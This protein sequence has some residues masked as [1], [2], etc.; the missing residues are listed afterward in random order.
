MTV[1]LF[2]ARR[3]FEAHQVELL[4]AA[5]RVLRSGSWILG[6]EVRAF[7]LEV[8]EYLGVK[9]AVGVASGSD[10]LILALKSLGIGPGDAVVT[11]PFTFF[12]T[13]GAIVNAGAE[14]V[15]ADIDP[16]S[17]DL[18]PTC[19]RRILD[20]RSS[21][22]QRVGV[23]PR[24]IKAVIPV[25]LFGLPADLDAF[26]GIRGDFGVTLIE[27]AAQAFGSTWAGRLVGSLGELGCFSFFPTKNLGGFGDAGMVV[28]DSD[29]H[30][31]RLRLLRAHG[32]K[33]KY[34][35]EVV[36]MN[37]RLDAL[38]AALLRV[39]LHHLESSLDARSRHAR[40]YDDAFRDVPGIR[41]S[42]WVQGRTHHQYV[43]SLP[44]RDQVRDSLTKSGIATAV[45]YPLPL[46]LHPALARL[47]YEIGDF[48][49]SETASQR[50]LSIPIFPTMTE[51]ER[52][53]VIDSVIAAATDSAGWTT[54]EMEDIPTPDRG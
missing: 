53:T 52:A 5:E 16:I 2:D 45:H 42:P 26:E 41:S 40:A 11:T 38:Q 6:P 44:N 27:D 29:E 32:A 7:E 33:T 43:I 20:G 15:F 1:A 24:A 18:D 34:V 10:A 36:G 54:R 30:D 37:S 35:N 21:V 23:D 22:H 8:A 19:V 51:R 50:A 28:T 48:P 17:M 39:Q 12:A 47:G 31:E 13:A 3:E 14:P 49:F 46:H 25:H 4:A 9:H